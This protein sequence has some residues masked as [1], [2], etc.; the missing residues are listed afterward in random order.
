MVFEL[1]ELRLTK[2]WVLVG[3]LVLLYFLEGI[4]PF[5]EGRKE[6]VNHGM[7]N[8]GLGILNSL[9][10]AVLFTAALF[11]IE[12]YT[13]TNNF[14]ILNQFNLSLLW[15]AIIAIVLFDSWMYA[16][17]VM[18]HKIPFL[19]RFHLVHHTDTQVDATSALRF[20][21][22]E[23]I[24]STLGRLGIIII[25]GLSLWHILLYEIILLPVITFHHSNV[26][27]PEKLDK[28]YRLV[29]VSPH[30]HRIHHSDINIETDS[31]YT[32]VFSIWD[33]LFKTFRLREDPK[34][35][36]QG[37]NPFKDRKWATFKAMLK[38]PF[39]Y[40]K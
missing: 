32:S 25:F 37:I 28:V 8:I 23:I 2:T 22:L 1:L 16:W 6:R 36:I 18:N 20:H 19:W 30:M 10:I 12:D 11:F 39:I 34:K 4:F 7:K 13:K 33:R 31:N 15:S 26:R 29:F 3:M 5:Y 24:F 9:V 27:L 40:K 38:L 35:I 17:H 21:T 14:G